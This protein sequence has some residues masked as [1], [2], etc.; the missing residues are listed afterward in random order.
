MALTLHFPDGTV[1]ELN[2]S[3]GSYRYRKI[4]ADNELTLTFALPQA[5]D[6]PLGAYTDFLGERYTI[7]TPVSIKKIHSANYEYT[8][9]M[10]S[11]QA[12]LKRYKLRDMSGTGGNGYDGRLK[13]TL[14]AKPILH[15]QNLVNNLNNREG[16]TAWVLGTCID[17]VEKPISYNHASCWDALQQ[18][19]SEFETEW[20]IVGTTIHLHRVEYNTGAPLPLSYGRGNGFRS[21][22]ARTNPNNKNPIEILFVQGGERNIDYSVYG[23]KELLLPKNQLLTIDDRTYISD[24]DGLSIR[25]NDKQL[26]QKYEDSVDLS[27][28]YPKRVGTITD[29]QCIS[30]EAHF[31]DFIDNTIPENLDYSQYRITGEKITIIFQSGILAGKEF[32]IMQSE[33]AVNGYVHAERRFKIVPQEIDGRTMP[34]DIFKPAVG[35]FYAVFGM[36]MPD[37]YVC[38]N[39]AQSG[40]SW[41]MFRE[42]AK[43]LRENEDPKFTFT[44]ELDPIY[45]KQHWENIKDK[46]RLGGTISFNDTEIAQ[47]SVKIRIVGIK[48]FVNNPY[49][50]V[51][52]LSNDTPAGSILNVLR[53]IDANEVVVDDKFSDSMAFARR[54]FRDVEETSRMLELSQFQTQTAMQFLA[55][56]ESLQFDFTA[57]ASA[58]AAAADFRI[59]WD[60]ALKTIATAPSAVILRHYTIASKTTHLISTSNNRELQYWNMQNFTSPPLIIPDKSYYFYAKC[61]KLSAGSSIGNGSFVL[62][63]SPIVLEQ[64]AGYWHFLVA[65]VNSEYDGIRNIASMFGF[66]E[67]LPGRITTDKIVSSNGNTYFDMQNNEIGGRINFKDGLISGEIGV[68]NANGI[69]AGLSGL[70]SGSGGA[71]AATDVRMWAGASAASK[72]SAPFRVQHDGKLY[73]SNADIKGKINATEG[74]FENVKIK[75]RLN[76]SEMDVNPVANRMIKTRISV[77]YLSPG[78]DLSI[79]TYNVVGWADANGEYKYTA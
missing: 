25:R 40:A 4:M 62:S 60:A 64:Q 5:V 53:R 38:N 29:I 48:D 79:T 49:K 16:N 14:T 70:G 72:N 34:D 52:D 13:F 20:E 10:H 67:I 15:L 66:T 6:F 27:N 43:Y 78:G 24:A 11:P 47:D 58:A 37:E 31:W 55:G 56:D 18:I 8:M 30:A 41:D 3:D 50:P 42:A 39:A 23:S 74:E 1:H 21:G 59:G 12:R 36:Q 46:L 28:I 19:A 7:E 77:T 26:S 22:V 61:Q 65:L 69:N 33:G 68:G 2:V 75:G 32:E 44:G 76:V 54:R 35:D 63:E 51:L 71:N 73:A 45:A 57:Q 9:L 17:A